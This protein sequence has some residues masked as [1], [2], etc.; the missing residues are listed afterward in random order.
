M[1]V[2]PLENRDNF[3][4]CFPSCAELKCTSACDHTTAHCDRA[5]EA[6]ERRN[7]LLQPAAIPNSCKIKTDSAHQNGKRYPAHGALIGGHPGVRRGL[8]GQKPATQ[9]D[10]IK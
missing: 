3:K 7:K 5:V 9:A 4:S 10:R 8:Q 6:M 1:T 2:Q